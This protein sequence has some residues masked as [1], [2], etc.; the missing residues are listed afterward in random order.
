MSPSLPASPT[1]AAPIARFWGEI[2]LP[3]TPPELLA[4]ASST[5]ERP[6]P[7]AAS[8]WSAPNSALED[9]SEPVMATP[10]QPTIG[11]RNANRPPE[12]ATQRPSVVVIP[13]RF[14]T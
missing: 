10:S 12:P 11:D 3:S 1:A 6:A 5:S 9:V 14:I 7:F 13:V 4:E 2:I 8:T